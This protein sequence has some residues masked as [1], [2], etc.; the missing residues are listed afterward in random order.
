MKP[1]AV[2]TQFKEG[3]T[4]AIENLYHRAFFKKWLDD[5]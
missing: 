4:Q 1:I 5:L 3:I 2:R